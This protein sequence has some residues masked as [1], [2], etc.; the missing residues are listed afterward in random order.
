M[1]NI[2]FHASLMQTLEIIAKNQSKIFMC[3]FLLSVKFFIQ[4]SKWFLG[5]IDVNKRVLFHVKWYPPR[6][7]G[8]QVSFRMLVLGE[9][10]GGCSIR[11][12]AEVGHRRLL[13]LLVSPALTTSF[14]GARLRC[15][16]VLKSLL[17]PFL[18]L[19]A[20]LEP[21]DCISSE[22]VRTLLTDRRRLQTFPWSLLSL[23]R[24]W[25]LLNHRSKGHFPPLQ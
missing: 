1:E 15:H 25:I 6:A 13:A 2:I 21:W 20:Y 8:V 12:T 17:L 18:N 4:I 23:F 10:I 7:A 16:W 14:T 24:G 11:R 5:S 19:C 22:D 9:A 3:L